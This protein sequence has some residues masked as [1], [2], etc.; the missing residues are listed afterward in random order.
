MLVLFVTSRHEPKEGSWKK[1]ERYTGIYKFLDLARYRL[2]LH[3]VFRP[4]FP[5]KEP[6]LIVEGVVRQ[7]RL[8][9]ICIILHYQT[10]TYPATMQS[11]SF[12]SLN[13]AYLRKTLLQSCM[14]L[15]YNFELRPNSRALRSEGSVMII[16][17]SI[18][19]CSHS[20]NQF[21]ER[22]QD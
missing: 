11:L 12:V 4:F 5:N 22:K 17:L 19:G 14:L 15:G 20:K 6:C 2:H 9:S 7:G 8:S 3:P 13:L 16:S 21:E 1:I 10:K 18:N